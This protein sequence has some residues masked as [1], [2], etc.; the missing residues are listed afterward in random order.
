MHRM[1]RLE[2][3]VY[4]HSEYHIPI[5]TRRMNAKITDMAN[6]TET[7]EKWQNPQIS[8]ISSVLRPCLP[9]Q[10][11]VFELFPTTGSTKL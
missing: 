10:M 2:V 5:V 1:E 6:S 7:K 4:C 3:L 8:G 9:F 11:H